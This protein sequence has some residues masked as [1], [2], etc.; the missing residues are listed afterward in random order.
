[1]LSGDLFP[2]HEGPH[3]VCCAYLDRLHDIPPCGD[4]PGNRKG[5]LNLPALRS[6]VLSV[7]VMGS[8][9][10]SS[11]CYQQPASYPGAARLYQRSSMDGRS[12]QKTCQTHNMQDALNGPSSWDKEIVPYGQST[13]SPLMLSSV[14]CY[15]WSD[16]SRQH[17]CDST[18]FW[19]SG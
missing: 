12:L 14:A 11:A 2:E 10:L 17:E 1:M 9:D 19:Q 16:F 3:R 5:I 13:K 15:T 4:R 7:P 6:C 18:A 8:T